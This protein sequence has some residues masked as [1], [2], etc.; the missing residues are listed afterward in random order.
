[1]WLNAGDL[2]FNEK[3]QNEWS[4]KIAHKNVLRKSVFVSQWRLYIPSH[5]QSVQR[6]CETVWML[7]SLKHK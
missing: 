4:V 3:Y 2:I 1:M 7:F 5:T 6:M